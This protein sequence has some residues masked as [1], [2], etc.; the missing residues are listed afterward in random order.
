MPTGGVEPT[1][2]SLRAWFDAGVVAVGMGT[3]LIDK[4]L[5]KAGDFGAISET[6]QQTLELIGQLKGK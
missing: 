1:T 6:V 2:E 4:A 3:Q 5:V